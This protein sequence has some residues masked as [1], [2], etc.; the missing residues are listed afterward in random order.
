[1]EK[2]KEGEMIYDTNLRR[3]YKEEE[4]TFGMKKIRKIKKFKNQNTLSDKNMK[5]F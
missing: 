4:K 2:E 1:M 5:T 3:K